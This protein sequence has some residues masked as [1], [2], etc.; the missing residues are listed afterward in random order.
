MCDINRATLYFLVIPT[1]LKNLT[2]LDPH[3]TGGKNILV[4]SKL[5]VQWTLGMSFGDL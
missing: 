1:T 4:K 5:F 2:T 3:L